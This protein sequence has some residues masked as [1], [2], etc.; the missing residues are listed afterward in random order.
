MIWILFAAAAGIATWAAMGMRSGAVERQKGQP[1]LWGAGATAAVLLALGIYVEVQQQRMVTRIMDE[2]T[3]LFE[4]AEAKA[5][6]RRAEF[7]A[8]RDEFDRKFEARQNAFDR[9][10]EEQGDRIDRAFSERRAA[11]KDQ[12]IPKLDE[13]APAESRPVP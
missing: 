2:G 4:R 9:S 3:D 7:Q 10:F 1:L 12:E 6:V 5:D 11:M 8:K 13:S